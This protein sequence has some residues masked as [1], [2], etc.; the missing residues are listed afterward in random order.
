MN[1]GFEGGQM[2]LHRRV[3]KRGFTNLFRK[4][5]QEVNVGRLA[6]FAAGATV[7]AKTLFQAGI[8]DDPSQRVKILGNGELKTALTV[9]ADAFSKGARK[10]IEAAGG[11]AE[12]RK[13]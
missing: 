9:V 7:D 12:E 11:K 3:P 1:P 6:S 2:P 13:P 4:P 5:T 8:V 10:A